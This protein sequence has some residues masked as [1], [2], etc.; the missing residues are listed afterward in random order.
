VLEN[1]SLAVEVSDPPEIATEFVFEIPVSK[2][3]F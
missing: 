3:L 2:K 1:E